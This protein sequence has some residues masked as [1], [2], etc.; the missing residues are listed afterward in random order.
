MGTKLILP[1]FVLPS[2][3]NQRWKYSGMDSIDLC[4]DQQHFL[5]YPHLVEY[6]YNSR[7]YRDQEWPDSLEELKNAVWCVGDSFTV[8]IGQPFDHIWPQVL[9]KKSNQRSI[10]IS[11]DGASNDWIARKVQRVI[12]TV[13]PKNIVIMWSYTHRREHPDI[14]MLDEQRI[15]LSDKTTYQE[16]YLHWKNLKE[17]IQTL[18]SHVIQTAIPDFV[19]SSSPSL[20][21]HWNAIRGSS[22][23]E[24]PTTLYELT[25]LPKNIKHELETIHNCYKTFEIFLSSPLGESLFDLD[26]QTVNRKMLPDDVIYI[27]KQLD[28]ARDYHHFDL[29]T[30]EWVV[31]QVC[32]RLVL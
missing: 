12:D 8:G 22:W 28:R 4:L 20:T 31:E 13:S 19:E 25:H 16:D 6:V 15:M 10:N 27:H 17:Q 18:N 9:S 23:P 7:G 11:M 5:S 1:D 32:S 24:C 30:S 29:L 14:K 2:R 26:H 3:V 21:Q